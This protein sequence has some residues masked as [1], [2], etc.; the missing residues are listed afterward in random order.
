M[1]ASLRR[2]TFLSA[3][4]WLAVGQ[5]DFLP[6]WARAVV[7]AADEQPPAA[8]PVVFSDD[9]EPLVRAIEQ[10]PAERALELAV[11]RLKGGTTPRQL[12]AAIFLAGIRNVNP[13]PPGFKL[14][15][16]FAVQAAHQL[17]LD[18]PTGDRLLPLL[19]ALREFKNSQAEDARH[20]A[21]GD[22]DDGRSPRRPRCGPGTNR[23][24]I[25]RLWPWFAVGEPTR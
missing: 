4:G 21:A 2:R 1:N 3:C 6:G 24:P 17:S 7:E 15:C 13:Q 18:V 12:L 14:H 19:W 11:A 22:G 20:A 8:E 16:V 10:V 9:L 25:G 5:A 23:G